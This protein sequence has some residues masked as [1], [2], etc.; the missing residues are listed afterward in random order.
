MMRAAEVLR[1]ARGVT[2]GASLT[3]EKHLPHA[4]GIG[5]GSSDAA[6]TLAMLAEL[7]R[8][9]PLPAMT[10]EVVALGADVPVCVSSPRPL[11]MSGI[12]DVLSPVEQLPSCCY[13]ASN[14][15]P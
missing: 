5:S 9:A 11:R 6:T 2:K 13:V 10:P 15:Y 1:A 3:L 14:V 4:A 8:V 7:W 12:G